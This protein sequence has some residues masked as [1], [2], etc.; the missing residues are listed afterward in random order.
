MKVKHLIWTNEF[1]SQCEGV[2]REAVAERDEKPISDVADSEM[3]DEFDRQ[4]NDDYE[5]EKMNLNALQET[6]YKY[7]A[8]DRYCKS[9]TVRNPLSLVQYC[10]LLNKHKEVE[11]LAKAGLSE[12]I[13]RNFL[14]RLSK[15]KSLR[16]FFRSHCKELMKA[17]KVYRPQTI[18]RAHA[19]GWSLEETELREHARYSLKNAPKGIDRIELMN[20]LVK[21]NI[22]I[23]DY[24]GYCRDIE[25]AKLNILDFGNTFPK[26]FHEKRIKVQEM[27]KIAQAK[28]EAEREKALKK[29]A[30]RV[31]KLLEKMRD[32]LAWRVGDFSVIVPTTR[33][34]FAEE[35]NAM[36]NCIGGYFDRCADGDTVCFFIRKSGKR[37]ADVEMSKSG[38]IRQCRLKNNEKADKE[39]KDFATIMAKKIANELRKAA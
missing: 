15:S 10:K 23:H 38:D 22:D 3:W 17:Q 11:F 24:Y 26:D 8:F 6:K 28:E 12:Y 5:C 37:L 31:N 18:I 14:D 13:E 4:V 34:Q 33:K 32:K 29:L 7:C 9:R 35:G 27:I 16:D 21:N 20:Y 30:I 25:H 2:Y 36:H 39:T 1:D 19:N